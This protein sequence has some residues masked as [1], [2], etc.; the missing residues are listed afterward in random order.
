LTLSE[1][2][3][4]SNESDRDVLDASVSAASDD[5]RVNGFGTLEAPP[6]RFRIHN[7]ESIVGFQ[8]RLTGKRKAL[9]L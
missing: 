4:V 7:Y 1:I 5:M 3:L 9:F 8:L 6:V 2:G